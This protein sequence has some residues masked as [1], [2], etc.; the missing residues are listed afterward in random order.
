M[1]HV[2]HGKE[3][4]MSGTMT[5]YFNDGR[6]YEHEN[7]KGIMFVNGQLVINYIDDDGDLQT[8]RYTRDSLKDGN[9]I[10][11]Y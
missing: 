8:L 3:K 6:K 7:V 1:F 9:V 5:C 4:I 10:T 11:I 2:K